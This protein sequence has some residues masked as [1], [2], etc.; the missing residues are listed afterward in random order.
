MRDFIERYAE[1]L[2]VSGE[3][4][5][6]SDECRALVNAL[7]DAESTEKKLT[8]KRRRELA[9]N[10]SACLDLDGVQDLNFA[11]LAAIKAREIEL[12]DA[13]IFRM[14]SMLVPSFVRMPV[15]RG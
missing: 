4:P 13:D 9:D 14:A 11:V 8:K 5:G 1:T 12:S 15:L 2:D 10:I 7:D 6:A 3:Y